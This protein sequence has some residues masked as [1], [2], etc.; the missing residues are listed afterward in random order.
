MQIQFQQSLN[1][2]NKSLYSITK[3]N[4]TLYLDEKDLNL[5]IIQLYSNCKSN[6]DNI[7]NL[8]SLNLELKCLE[9]ELI[10]LRQELSN[11]KSDIDLY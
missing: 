9:N 4:N 5:L 6:F 11:F 8:D 3:D 7:F 1:K 2:D 10:D